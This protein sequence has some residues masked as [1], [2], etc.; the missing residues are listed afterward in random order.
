[1]LSKSNIFRYDMNKIGLRIREER[2]SLG[3]NQT[4]FLDSLDMGRYSRQFLGRWEN[5]KELPPLD[6]LIAMCN[7]FHCEL[8]YLL[9]EHDCKT[10]TVTD[11]QYETGLSEKAINKIKKIKFMM[12]DVVTTLNGIIEHEDFYNLLCAIH[13]HKVTYNEKFFKIEDEYIEAMANIMRCSLEEA[14]YYVKASSEKLIEIIILQIVSDLGK[15]DSK[16]KKSKIK[17][18]QLFDFFSISHKD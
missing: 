5:G 1:M 13:T 11:I 7:A 3:L 2:K 6:F 14:N 18:K 12:R 16:R 10:R 4:D 17:H 8:G 15:N 9:C